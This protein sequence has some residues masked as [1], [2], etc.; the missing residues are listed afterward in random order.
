MSDNFFDL[1]KVELVILFPIARVVF[2]N[3]EI[4]D[5]TECPHVIVDVESQQEELEVVEV[6]VLLNDDVA[7][8]L[9]LFVDQ[10]EVV[11]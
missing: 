11:E 1:I 2:E 4:N 7:G 9:V 6:V 8:P 10:L 3:Y 5:Q